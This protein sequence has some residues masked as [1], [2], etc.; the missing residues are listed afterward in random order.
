MDK[1]LGKSGFISLREKQIVLK[2]KK[3]NK[4]IAV[5]LIQFDETHGWFAE[6]IEGKKRWYNPRYWEYIK[7]VGT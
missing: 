2:E 7:E 4:Q 3:K 6:N 1:K 5:K